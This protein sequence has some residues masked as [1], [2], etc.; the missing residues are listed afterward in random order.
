MLSRADYIIKKFVI[1][2]LF[3]FAK[4]II[5]IVIFYIIVKSLFLN[6]KF[7]NA[8]RSNTFG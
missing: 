5:A 4:E 8:N 1:I 3:I 7:R 2:I 6:K